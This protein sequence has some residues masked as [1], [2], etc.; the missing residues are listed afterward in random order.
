MN[1]SFTPI[2]SIQLTNQF[3]SE[4]QADIG[5]AFRD[6]YK[7]AKPGKQALRNVLGFACALEVIPTISNGSQ[8]VI[9][10]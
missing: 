3:H 4:M 1:K 7:K 6:V 9:I 2:H 5:R 10:N 8:Q